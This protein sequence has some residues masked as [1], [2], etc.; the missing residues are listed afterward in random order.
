M[1]REL[2]RSIVRNTRLGEPRG[3][4]ATCSATILP[5]A[6]ASTT[7]VVAS[8]TCTPRWNSAPGSSSTSVGGRPPAAV[9]V[10]RPTSR[11]SPSARRSSTM[12]PTVG[13]VS[14]VAWAS[15]VRDLGE[16]S[17]SRAST[18]RRFIARNTLGFPRPATG[19]DATERPDAPV[20]T[21]VVD[22]AAL[23][24]R[25]ERRPSA[26]QTPLVSL[27]LHR[28]RRRPTRPTD[29]LHEP[30]RRG[31][32]QM[33]DVNRVASRSPPQAAIGSRP[34]TWRRCAT[35]GSRRSAVR[36]RVRHRSGG[37]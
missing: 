28:R 10:P 22:R 19:Q 20:E 13:F 4:D 32:R 12:S 24:R 1:H 18:S 15:S 8:L 37:S 23:Q 35:G 2:S 16:P 17:T 34:P 36:C 3:V 7:V 26:H 33:T 14:A 27:V 31:I 21:A 30:E 29:S 25:D 5:V 6:S 11:T 9:G